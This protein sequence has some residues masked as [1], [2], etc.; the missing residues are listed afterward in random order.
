MACV[1][2]GDKQK[3]FEEHMK[4]KAKVSMAAC[5]EKRSERRREHEKHDALEMPFLHE[6]MANMTD[7]VQERQVVP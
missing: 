4:H 7:I 6:A 2:S 1:H 3:D 5:F